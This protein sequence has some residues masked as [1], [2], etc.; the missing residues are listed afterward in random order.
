MLG[1]AGGQSRMYSRSDSTA[2]GDSRSISQSS[3]TLSEAPTAEAAEAAHLKPAPS[4]WLL[5]TSPTETHWKLYSSGAR[6]HQHKEVLTTIS[7]AVPAAVRNRLEDLMISVSLLV[8]TLPAQD[9]AQARMQDTEHRATAP[10]FGT[11]HGGLGGGCRGGAETANGQ[12]SDKDVCFHGQD[13]G[14]DADDAADRRLEPSETKH[15]DLATAAFGRRDLFRRAASAVFTGSKAEA[16]DITPMSARSDRSFS[17][18]LTTP[19]SDAP[20]P[21]PVS[22]QK[23][24]TVQSRTNK[25]MLQAKTGRAAP[26]PLAKGKT[27]R[28]VGG[29]FPSVDPKRDRTGLGG[30]HSI[31]VKHE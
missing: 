24:M 12:D 17:L 23:S 20:T 19:R 7:A 9:K 2:S 11:Q 18:S 28:N 29:Y 27:R 15:R 5:E 6:L 31:S 14:A 30:Y 3:R 4:H 26:M 16:Y 25:A 22:S 21:R 8:N 13:E 10:T 1:G